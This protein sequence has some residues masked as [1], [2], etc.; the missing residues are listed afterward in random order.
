M[1]IIE[2]ALGV[3][4]G[5]LLLANLDKV[6]TVFGGLLLISIV[7][8]LVAGIVWLCLEFPVIG[9][10]VIAIFLTGSLSMIIEAKTRFTE[11]QA[12]SIAVFFIFVLGLVG[13]LLYLI[14]IENNSHLAVS[15]AKIGIFVLIPAFFGMITIL[16]DPR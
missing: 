14:W 16:K 8:I 10:I 7:I 3:V 4:L 2:I 1:L 15:V 6:I 5:F 9:G 11:N 13:S 12:F